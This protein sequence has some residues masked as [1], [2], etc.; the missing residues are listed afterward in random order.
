MY[1]KIIISTGSLFVSVLLCCAAVWAATPPLVSTQWLADHL[2]DQGVVIIDVR[3]ETNYGV[4]HIP[5]SVNL[6][7]TGWEPLN[8]KKQCQLM[9]TPD[10]FTVMLR[11]KGVSTGSHVIIYDHGNSISDATKGTASAWIL[12][13]MGQKKV[14][15]LDGGFTKWTFEG[16]IID[17]Q[18]PEPV[19]GDF[20]A[21]LDSS[22]VTGLDELVS[23]M[24]SGNVL[25]V[26]AR[27][28]NQHFGNDKRADVNRFGH[29]P[30]SLNLPAPF[31]SNAGINRAPATFRDNQELTSIV[32]GV[33]IPN[34]KN[35]EIIV[36]CNTGQ[37][38][39]MVYFA[40]HDLLGY[41]NVSVYDA[42]MR[43]Y[44][45]HD[46]L[47]LVRFAWGHVQH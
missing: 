14:S 5:G 2:A 25:L 19:P 33:G 28:S 18:K 42:S 6:P 47:S 34:D 26:D 4:G 11:E 41:R 32:E 36:Y 13:T 10:D 37:Y 46:N 21:Q 15:Y 45:A 29:I 44:G 31:L 8:V 7:Y 43:E 17:N 16:R 24:Q 39:G 3:T 1:K 9:P 38:A 30:G 40:L 12:S 27:N 22:K 20:K 23:R 35:R